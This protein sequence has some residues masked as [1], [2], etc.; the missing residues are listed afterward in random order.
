[1]LV[2]R[3]FDE[4]MFSAP[5]HGKTSFYMKSLGEEA[6]GAAPSF[7]LDHWDILAVCLACLFCYLSN[8][9]NILMVHPSAS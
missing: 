6:F 1:M 3:V 8:K 7:L 4:C 5:R 2:T 9:V